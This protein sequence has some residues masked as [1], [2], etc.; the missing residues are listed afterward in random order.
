MWNLCRLIVKL[1]GPQFFFCN[2]ANYLNA[3]WDDLRIGWKQSILYT[4][5]GY[6]IS[7]MLQP[8]SEKSVRPTRGWGERRGTG[9]SQWTWKQN[10]VQWY[11]PYNHPV[12]SHFEKGC[13]K[14][15]TQ[16][17]RKIL[18]VVLSSLFFKEIWKNRM[19][20]MD[21]RLR[22]LK[23]SNKGRLDSY[24]VREQCIDHIPYYLLGLSL[25][26]FFGKPVSK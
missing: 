18:W 15:C 19:S 12:Y 21:V 23:E 6:Q 2:V 4:F 3:S 25:P 11:P 1:T 13:R 24:S 16:Q 9:S 26:H 7:R 10:D 22:V 17:S 20:P 5:P 14:K 8:F